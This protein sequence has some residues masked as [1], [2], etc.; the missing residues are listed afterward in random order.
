MARVL[1]KPLT[2]DELKLQLGAMDKMMRVIE[3]A[4]R[5]ADFDGVEEIRH[6]IVRHIQTPLQALVEQLDAGVD[7]G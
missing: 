5:G 2:I 4:I 6:A 7:H 3:L 1:P